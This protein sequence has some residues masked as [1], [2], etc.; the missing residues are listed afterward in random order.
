M[1]L[2]KALQRSAGCLSD[3][4]DVLQAGGHSTRLV[5]GAVRDLLLAEIPKDFDLAT[6]ARPERIMELFEGKTDFSVVPT[7]LKHGTV[8]VVCRGIPYEVTTLR[9]DVETDGR[10]AA[11]EFTDNWEDDARR[12][13]FTINA[14]G[15]DI[16]TGVLYDYF[17]GEEDL[18]NGRLRFVGNA[19]ER[20]EEDYLRILRFF[21][22]LGRYEHCRDLDDEAV[23]AI[24]ASVSGLQHISGERIWMEMSKILVS[25]RIAMLAVLM[26]QTRVLDLVG[27]DPFGP[28]SRL[29]SLGDLPDVSVISDV[30]RLAESPVTMLA[31]LLLFRKVY[32]V[33]REA[34]Q[35][36]RDHVVESWKI[37][38]A[39]RELLDFLL[40]H[41][42]GRRQRHGVDR[43]LGIAV[44][45][46][47]SGRTLELCA[48][49]G[50]E[51]AMDYLRQHPLAVFPVSGQDLLDLGYPEGPK[52]GVMLAR[53][54]K[55][56]KHTN[57]VLAKD[58]LLEHRDDDTY[59]PD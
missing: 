12:R 27:L 2:K 1:I 30:R 42:R 37:S 51:G 10:H 54:K 31:A 15:I 6:D 32:E 56:W 8:T 40:L 44:D 11:V 7:G 23:S 4:D 20:I 52:V 35:D 57:Y 13:D 33:S 58:E 41:F 19:Q 45:D 28:L 14:M 22:F 18:V 43:Y 36:M 48:L 53:M 21:R 17:G 24:Q 34:V 9:V 3:I 59:D 16:R 39:E 50:A 55:V 26:E 5:G 25:P 38:K 46:G 49:E 29:R 47:V